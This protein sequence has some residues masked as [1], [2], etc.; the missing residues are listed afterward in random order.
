MLITLSNNVL[1][2]SFH[3]YQTELF[4]TRIRARAVGFTYSFSRISTVFAAFIIG[5]FLNQAGSQGVFGLIAFAMLVVVI[6]MACSVR[7]QQPGVGRDFALILTA[8]PDSPIALLDD[9]AQA[10]TAARRIDPACAR[11]PEAW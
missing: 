7:D 3:G 4:P 1:S 6:S 10:P 11:S 2:Y 9:L 8:R 5:W